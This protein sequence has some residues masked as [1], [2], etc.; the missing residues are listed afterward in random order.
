MKKQ[1][2]TTSQ[3]L[4]SKV[5]IAKFILQQG[6]TSKSEIAKELK[7]SMPTI[8]LST[9]ELIDEKIIKEVGEYDLIDY[10]EGKVTIKDLIKPVSGTDNIYLIPSNLNNIYLDN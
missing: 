5:R 10:F 8:L 9:K 2:E 6:E 1:T 7:I 3:I 4:S